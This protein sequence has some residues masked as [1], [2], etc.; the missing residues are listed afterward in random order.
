MD[1][2]FGFTNNIY[3]SKTS[4]DIPANTLVYVDGRFLVTLDG[5]E[6]MGFGSRTD[7]P[8]YN[9]RFAITEIK[10]SKLLQLVVS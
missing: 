8:G 6:R 1:K 4:T 9:A 5:Q 3:V 10:F 7:E 2:I